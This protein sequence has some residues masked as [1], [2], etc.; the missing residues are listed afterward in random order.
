MVIRRVECFLGQ[1]AG[2]YS[3]VG[4]GPCESEID[5]NAVFDDY[6]SKDIPISG[7][8]SHTYHQSRQSE[9]VADIRRQEGAITPFTT[10][11]R[12]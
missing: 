5:V 3:L 2:L 11:H 8:Q 6:H 4:M 12:M 10:N 9:A 1:D 7:G